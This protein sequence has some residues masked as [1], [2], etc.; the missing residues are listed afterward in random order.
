MSS[1]DD[2]HSK[3]GVSE[4]P[5][6]QICEPCNSEGR[7]VK[8]VK[9][10]DDCK[11]FLCHNC[12]D[13]HKKYNDLRCHR[14]LSL[15][16]EFKSETTECT[17]S[18][19]L[20]D[21][22]M[23]LRVSDF[24]E[25]HGE[26]ICSTCKSIKHMKCKTVTVDEKSKT[27]DKTNLGTTIEKVKAINDEVDKLLVDRNA[28]LQKLMTIR[29]TCR[30][31]IRKFRQELNKHLDFLE[32]KI[33]KELE[34]L[35]SQERQEIERHISSCSASRQMIKFDSVLLEDAKNSS[36]IYD[37]FA[38]DKKVSLHL[39]EYEML[40]QEVNQESRM[41]AITFH[42]LEQLVEIQKNINKL[43]FLR[44]GYVRADNS[45]CK[46][47]P[48]IKVESSSWVG[49]KLSEDAKT[50]WISGCDVMQDG[51]VVVCDREN[52]KVKLIDSALILKD[53]LDLLT[54]PWDVSAISSSSIN[55]SCI[56]SLPDVKQLQYIEVT[57]ILKTG[58]GIQLDKTCWGIHV[59]GEEI[60]ITCHDNSGE[61]TGEV[62]ILDFDG[63]LIRKI[64]MNQD[65]LGLFVYPSFLTVC[66][67]SGNIYVSD[68][69]MYT[70][71]V[72]CLKSDGSVIYQYKD[73]YLKYPKGL[74]VDAKGNILVC[75]EDSNNVQIITPTGTKHSTL[76]TAKDGSK[77][78]CSVAY[79]QSDDTLIVGCRWQSKMF[80]Y[81]LG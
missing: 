66:P 56:V 73:P 79:R 9:V 20:C 43:G 34:T 80:V 42:R 14:I 30:N 60:Y 65:G 13:T 8:A 52:N 74:C 7:E 51:S 23:I 10:C 1:A 75:G 57:P 62:R 3:Q 48:N 2:T 77:C 6:P 26:V 4:E 39:K 29:E 63:T 46:L 55:A 61:S 36:I 44:T 49:M 25:D 69:Y 41:P 5:V 59:A 37:M 70:S 35:E 15:P 24:C 47:F 72:I 18:V 16:Q 33:L 22:S 81:K 78:P 28:D 19:V 38:A 54:P 50:P 53:S 64:G 67:F 32:E 27:Y 12:T 71:P 76:L 40:L 31:E 45:H 58:P 11:E 68:R 17:S 21:C